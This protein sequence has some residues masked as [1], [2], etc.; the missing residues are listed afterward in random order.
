MNCSRSRTRLLRFAPLGFAGALIAAGCGGSSTTKKDAGDG[1]TGDGGAVALVLSPGSGDFGS[2]E[3]GKSSATPVQFKVSVTGVG[4]TGT[5]TAVVTGDFKIP[6]GGNK[7]TEALTGT[8]TCTIDVVFSPSSVG[9]K[10]G[11][12][13]V[14]ASPGGSQTA[15][16][17]GNGA[18]TGLKITPETRD[19]GTAV[20]AGA[21]TTITFSVENNGGVAVSALMVSV[22]GADFAIPMGGS[23][24]GA[25]LDVGAK[26]AVDVQ[27]SPKMAGDRTGTL[28]ATGTA[29]PTAVS[30]TAGLSGKAQAASKL[31]VSPA[32]Q[33]FAAAVGQTSATITFTIANVGDAQSGVPAVTLGGTNATD[34]TLVN[35]G[36]ITPLA[37]NG[38]CQ[39]GVAFK[40]TAEGA[41][42]ASLSVAGM[43]GGTATSALSGTATVGKLTV[44]PTSLDF[45][46][47]SVGDN[48][49]PQTLTITNTG[50]SVSGALQVVL[51]GVDSSNFSISSNN[52][53]GA[54]LDPNATCTLQVGF[55]PKAPAGQK[56][57]IVTVS[58]NPGG[59]VA[60]MIGGTALSPAVLSVA[61]ASFDY[62][63]IPANT[64]SDH[65]F[66]VSNAGGAN[67]GTITTTLTGGSYLITSNTCNAA[68]IPTGTCTIT[69][70]FRPTV[71]GAFP[72][73]L[74][75]AGTPGGSQTVTLNG[76]A[77][78]PAAITVAST[79]ANT[80]NFNGDPAVL[81][82]G[83]VIGSMTAP[84][85]FTV[86]NAGQVPTGTLAISL[87]GGAAADY[88]I[89]SNGCTT[90]APGTACLVT[91][92]FKPTATG[93]RIASLLAMG[94]G[95]SGSAALT[96]VGLSA[97]DLTNVAGA[98][99][100]PLFD[101]GPLS[102][103][104][105][106]ASTAVFQANIRSNIGTLTAA[107]SGENFPGNY[108]TPVLT[109]CSHAIDATVLPTNSATWVHCDVEVK[110]SPKD[111]VT[112]DA[113]TIKKGNV[114]VTSANN[115]STS[116]PLEGT[117]T[118]PL[119][120]SPT[121][122]SFAA[123]PVN[124]TSD[125]VLT[126]TVGG[127]AGDS[128]GPFTV[129]L[130]GTDVSQFAKVADACTGTTKNQNQTCAITIRFA[131]TTAGAKV[132]SL[133]VSG[134]LNH[135]GVPSGTTQTVVVSLSGTAG[136][137]QM[138]TAAPTALS[139]AATPAGGQSA[140]QTITVSNPAAAAAI[141]GFT[142]SNG[143]TNPTEF[144]VTASTCTSLA[145][146]A[147]C[148]LTVRFNPLAASTGSK[149][150]NIT[151]DAGAGNT[152]VVTLAGTV[153][154]AVTIAP[155]TNNFGNV[156]VGD[157]TSPA[158]NFTLT[159]NTAA[160]FTVAT[161]GLVAGT[162]S[163]PQPAAFG[164]TQGA[165]SCAGG[166]TI[167]PGATCVMSV[168]FLP[169]AGPGVQTANLQVTGAIAGMVGTTLTATS[170]LTGTAVLDA[171]L[172]IQNIADASFELRDFGEVAIA[173]TDMRTARFKLLNSGGAASSP[174]TRLLLVNDANFS[175]TP[176]TLSSEFTLSAGAGMCTEGQVL[177]AA[178][179][180]GDSCI[181]EVVFQPT[182][183]TP[184][185]KA[186]LQVQA[187]GLRG[188][189]TGTVRLQ[190]TG[191]NAA[192][193]RVDA[194]NGHD[195]GTSFSGASAAAGVDF[196]LTN[197]HPT[198]V[199][200]FINPAL[201]S[202]AVT[203]PA[204]AV[205]A[206]FV[207]GAPSSGTSCLP[208][209]GHV[210]NPGESCNFKVTF[211]PASVAAGNERAL[212]TLGNAGGVIKTVLG[213]W[214]RVQQDV[215][216]TVAD[217]NG[218]L[219]DATLNAND[220][221]F[222]KIV[223]G[224]TSATKVFVVKNIGERDSGAISVN[225]TGNFQL[226]A[227]TANNCNGG[228]AA[229]NGGTC[230]VG[231]KFAPASVAAL[232]GTIVV[233]PTV[234]T[235]YTANIKGT[236]ASAAN[237]TV[238]AVGAV[239]GN[240][241]L[242]GK[243]TR[244]FVVLNSGA[245]NVDAGALA[246]SLVGANTQ[247]SID[248]SNTFSAAPAGGKTFCTSGQVL[249]AAADCVVRVLW[250]PATVATVS[251]ILNVQASPG[252]DINT[253]VSGTGIIALQIKDDVAGVDGDTVTTAFANPANHTFT[254][255][256]SATAGA[257]GI[258]TVTLGAADQGFS[259]LTN[260]CVNMSLAAS[261]HCDVTV[262]YAPA[263]AGV[264][265]TTLTVSGSTAGN[266]VV[267]TMNGS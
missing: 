67:T 65:S 77:S 177:A 109:N 25:T 132:G 145:P 116:G 165:P 122:G 149:S 81:N 252:G 110:F 15:S 183:T 210:L 11:T 257:S 175:S 89:V 5:P 131:P 20:V 55:S 94:M 197:Q 18:T 88:S 150:A 239:L 36:C 29:G 190:G 245:T 139:F 162:G 44:G 111:P 164:L 69:V 22:N 121:A 148:Q 6:A 101:F 73:T 128:I 189:S 247:F 205:A 124:S 144:T 64:T 50:T 226:D 123:T 45:M 137:L 90:L 238:T 49:A 136:V 235:A 181:L 155:A 72:G 102:V 96:G 224:S 258:L 34:F 203:G 167:N 158:V 86:T 250:T 23:K 93:T 202:I 85:S 233:T 98:L 169:L 53:Q 13:T 4:T 267:A 138:I 246:F 221:D 253:T 117:A 171:N 172:D 220:Y 54:T 264:R 255:T 265:T 126:V 78:M 61:P 42:A 7:C 196:T 147:T 118:G 74:T 40:P 30:A 200:T 168:K 236:G 43:P 83:T 232:A 254:I 188:G 262:R 114:V 212:I 27:F 56:S 106:T 219:D 38:T 229:A 104:S 119:S 17:N 108:I 160:V 130:G 266:S 21:G 251:T 151:I 51:G 214:G 100:P 92:A 19:F 99:Y 260:G 66:T 201:A 143:G 26:C 39:I 142:V 8:K 58:G 14:S 84:V 41:K 173:G 199:V 240:K 206:D 146:G 63:T 28:L 107:V 91:V 182:L 31:I 163:N 237:L 125:L 70:S 105:V 222:G 176:N 103:G 216:V 95:G 193:L 166:S 71:A 24:C 157:A 59:S 231:V 115:T 204:G 46:S 191:I 184:V 57:A 242:G 62:M 133:T 170:A 208:F 244:D 12:L 1:G 140:T 68:L 33:S 97:L 153:S 249:I 75:V 3:V 141:A 223:N 207:I 209:A 80:G 152:A 194:T 52:C 227:T 186:T 127:A 159:N 135:N 60:A 180:A 215:V 113:A 134:V 230:N 48:S 174:I 185:R 218:V 213:V 10:N 192:N 263:S 225:V 32:A 47:A 9:G 241:P 179:S 112:T 256:N 161:V 37:G 82:A 248:Q 259:I 154:A 76:A 129:A 16:L 156:I 2:V 35:N 120:I 234:G 87:A 198:N 243:F 228:T 211:S 217:P 187:N 261:A 195:L 178:G 79:V